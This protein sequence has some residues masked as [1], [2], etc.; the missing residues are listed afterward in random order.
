MIKF[1]I[2]AAT[3]GG[4]LITPDAKDMK[5]A[6]DISKAHPF[7]TVQNAD[8]IANRIVHLLRN[9]ADSPTVFI[10]EAK[11][12]NG[13][14]QIKK[15]IEVLPQADRQAQR[16]EFPE[17]FGRELPPDIKG[18]EI[19]PIKYVIC[20]QADGDYLYKIEEFANLRRTVWILDPS[21]ALI[22]DTQFEAETVARDV[23]RIKQRNLLICELHRTKEHIWVKSVQE[24]FV[25]KQDGPSLN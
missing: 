20:N 15:E 23:I 10:R 19:A 5:W 9:R 21:E 11:Q 25:I 16:R 12:K 24:F 8:R 1:V 22:Y 18:P 3:E 6:E 4:Y 17:A 7:H 2:Y 13:T 14:W